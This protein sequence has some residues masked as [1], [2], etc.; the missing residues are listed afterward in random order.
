[1]TTFG[2]D[3]AVSGSESLLQERKSLRCLDSENY[4]ISPWV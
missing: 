4:W 2:T 1:M 3:E